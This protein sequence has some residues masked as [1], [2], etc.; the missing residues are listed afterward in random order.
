MNLI[1]YAALGAWHRVAC[2]NSTSVWGRIES[3]A[4]YLYCDYQTDFN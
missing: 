3:F 2:N 1:Y 4:A